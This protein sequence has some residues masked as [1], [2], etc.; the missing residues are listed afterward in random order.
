ML[1]QYRR[2]VAAGGALVVAD[3]VARQLWPVARNIARQYYTRYSGTRRPASSSTSSRSRK[4]RRTRARTPLVRRGRIV[5]R[6]GKSYEKCKLKEVCKFMKQQQAIHIHR[7]RHTDQIGTTAGNSNIRDYA[8]GGTLGAIENAMANLRYFD[9]NTNTLLTRDAS[10]SGFFRDI[11]VSIYRKVTVKN[12][13]Q[14]PVSVEV[15]SCVPKDATGNDALYYLSSG[16]SDQGNPGLSSAL[17]KV[18]DSIDLKNVYTVRTKIK[19][20]LQ[21]GQVAVCSSFSKAFDYSISTA[22]AHSL[23]YQ[24]KQGG[25]VWLM[26]VIGT[27]GHDNVVVGQVGLIPSGIDVL[28]DVEYR[29]KYDA[30]KDLHDI[31]VNDASQTSAFTNIPVTGC[32]PI[33][34]NQTY[35][36]A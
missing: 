5:R 24:K 22:D 13:M 2:P 23:A 10:A 11:N 21:P 36:L 28:F 18:S 8:Y 20:I 31:S 12:S 14:V 1:R 17:V 33:S 15:Y 4:R 3:R 35:S 30:G 6:K 34:D 25:H 9:P 16:L 27:L 19:K 7:E 26:R 29:L 32:K